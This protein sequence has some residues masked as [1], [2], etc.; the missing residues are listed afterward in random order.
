MPARIETRQP[1]AGLAPTP[2]WLDLAGADP[3]PLNPFAIDGVDA[4]G[5]FL[6]GFDR[7]A[8]SRL[9]DRIERR[10]EARLVAAQTVV[11]AQF[12]R[13]DG[14]AAFCR[15]VER[16]VQRSGEERRAV[17]GAPATRAALRLLMRVIG[18]P[19]SEPGEVPR[20]LR[21]RMRDVTRLLD[22]GDRSGGLRRDGLPFA[23]YRHDLDP[24]LK[25]AIP[26]S[27]R[28]NDASR[29][30][31]E[32]SAYSIAIFADVAL[33]AITRIA[34]IWPDFVIALPRLVQ[35]II[36]LPSAGFRSCSADRYA[37]LIILTASDETVFG[38]EESI[39]HEFAHQ[40]L[41]C[42]V[43]LDPLFV[44]HRKTR[45]ALPWSGSLRDAYGYFHAL[46]VYFTLAV[47]FDAALARPYHQR[48][49]VETRLSQVLTG[50]SKALPDFRGYPDFTPTGR[51]FLENLD[52]WASGLVARHAR[53]VA[54]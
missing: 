16:T 14:A 9:V 44:T 38:V 53:L 12:D 3:P 28:F 26:P 17:L 34:S 4:A 46:F 43:E 21:A 18:R 42:A 52:R 51:A 30:A 40:I 39:I 19:R 41:Y 13:V 5:L 29:R 49:E 25:L 35:G 37:G 32:R 8:L 15:A 31:D 11:E 2:H 7:G 54:Q 1:V 50:I 47:Y 48:D 23:V 24:V 20:G 36:H 33:A 45:Y 10:N 27:Y 6:P 22:D